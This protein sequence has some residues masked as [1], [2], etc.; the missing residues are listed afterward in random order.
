MNEAQILAEA[1]RE[2]N[3]EYTPLSEEA[4]MALA[5]DFRVK[6]Y[7]RKSVIVS[8]GQYSDTLFYIEKGSV[9]AYY[10]KDG[11]EITDWFAFDGDFICAINSYFQQVPS[12]HYIE[13]LED[14]VC[15]EMPKHRM[16]ALCD[17]HMSIQRLAL[18]GTTK[19]MLALQQRVV[20]LQFEN[21]KSKYQSLIELRPDIENRVP[22]TKIA[23][24][25]GITKETLSRIRA[26][27]N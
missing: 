20:S 26:Q 25:L 15:L 18:V 13:A 24:F 16:D 22:L 11:Q 9:H 2:I 5:D 6:S 12:P 8:E 17:Q 10:L 21:A 14:V 7:P 19:T 4:R 27:K 3:E 23:S 1:L